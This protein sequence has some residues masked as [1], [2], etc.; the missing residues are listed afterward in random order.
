M[1]TIINGT[2][3]AETLVGSEEA[4]IITTNGGLDTAFGFGGDD[5]ATLSNWPSLLA[6]DFVVI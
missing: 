1:A 3:A 4:D 2:A 6:N 5:L